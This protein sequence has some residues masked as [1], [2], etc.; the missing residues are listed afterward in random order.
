MVCRS[1]WN[2]NNS[3]GARLDRC[4]DCWNVVN[5]VRFST[6]GRA[7]WIAFENKAI[8]TSLGKI[9]ALPNI[10]KQMHKKEQSEGIH[11]GCLKESERGQL[12]W[13]FWS[14]CTLWRRMWP[15]NINPTK[16]HMHPETWA[17][18]P[19]KVVGFQ[20]CVGC[21]EMITRQELL[22][23]V[24]FVAMENITWHSFRWAFWISRS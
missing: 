9:I 15:S 23:N 16:I 18:I 11:D 10:Y 2:V 12:R 1:R 14:F 19:Q 20:F 24:V 13:G 4:F 21:S 8:K 17:G 5:V 22:S 3:R 7:E 6:N